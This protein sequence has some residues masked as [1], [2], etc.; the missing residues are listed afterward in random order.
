MSE[1]YLLTVD[2]GKKQRTKKLFI[3]AT[4]GLCAIAACVYCMSE[5]QGT[6]FK[7]QMSLATTYV[8]N[9]TWTKAS[10]LDANQACYSNAD[11][12][13][14][15]PSASWHIHVTKCL[16]NIYGTASSSDKY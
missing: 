15:H 16:I 13:Y 5:S 14:T 10:Y 2:Q 6:L 11:S 9:S 7:D 8:W 1:Q 3:F 4:L 12:R